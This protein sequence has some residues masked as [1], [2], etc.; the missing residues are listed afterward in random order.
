MQLIFSVIRNVKL[1]TFIAYS[2]Y[3]MKCGVSVLSLL[4]LQCVSNQPMLFLAHFASGSHEFCQI[5]CRRYLEYHELLHSSLEEDDAT[6]LAESWT[7]R[8]NSAQLK[9][10]DTDLL[11][12]VQVL[13]ARNLYKNALIESRSK[14][15]R[16]FSTLDAT[17]EIR[18][19]QIV[20]F[21]LEPM[22]LCFL[23][24]LSTSSLLR[25]V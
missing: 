25:T 16:W 19:F 21:A 6:D 8:N 4:C 11:E 18:E 14:R 13:T 23:A 12:T 7:Y 20:I 2:I 10:T 22:V 1:S 15:G 17:N 9:E 24:K 5:I 3:Q